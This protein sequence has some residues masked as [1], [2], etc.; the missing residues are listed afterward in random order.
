MEDIIALSAILKKVN[1]TKAMLQPYSFSLLWVKHYTKFLSDKKLNSATLQHLVT[2]G[3]ISK[4]MSEK[5]AKS[6]LC[7]LHLRLAYEGNGEDG[8]Q[9]LFSERFNGSARITKSKK[10]ISS[11]AQHFKG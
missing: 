5:I 9:A 8:I 11:V 1:V 4:G 10:I 2:C 6:G 3:V 7:Y